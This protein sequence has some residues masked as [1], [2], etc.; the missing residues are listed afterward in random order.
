MQEGCC[1]IVTS[2]K[3]KKA[4]NAQAETLV[5]M[6][7]Y[8]IVD[9]FVRLAIPWGCLLLMV[10]WATGSLNALAGKETF[11]DIGI[12]VLGDFRVSEGVAYLFGGLGVGYGILQKLLRQ[13]NIERL[14]PRIKELEQH[15]HPQRTSSQLTARG[16]TRPEDLR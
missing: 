5:R 9:T 6:R 16:T 3:K 10:Y 15:V 8:D 2:K 13:R 7:R 1:H 4:S 12:R 14:A 11:A